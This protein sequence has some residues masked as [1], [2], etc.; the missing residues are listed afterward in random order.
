MKKLLF[1]ILSVSAASVAMAQKAQ[2]APL[3]NNLN[4][5]L[6]KPFKADSSLKF[7][8]PENLNYSNNMY[9]ELSKNK[10]FSNNTAIN[11]NPAVKVLEGNSKMPV[12]GLEG[13]SKM[14]V[15]GYGTPKPNN[16]DSVVVIP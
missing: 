16:R 14:P 5:E 6:L 7:L 3:D 15:A 9:A 12:V 1:L 8:K 4:S 10:A 11:Y 13:Y 2:T